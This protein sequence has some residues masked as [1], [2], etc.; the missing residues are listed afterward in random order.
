MRTLIYILLATA[1]LFAGSKPS[2]QQV[3][4]SYGYSGI[5]VRDDSLNIDT[6][7]A[8]AWKSVLNDTSNAITVDRVSSV[9]LSYNITLAQ[10]DSANVLLSMG[11]YDGGIAKWLWPGDYTRILDYTLQSIDSAFVLDT[12]VTGYGQRELFVRTCDKVK[13]VVSAPAQASNTDTV[14]I[15]TM[16]LRLKD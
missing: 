5:R 1:A 16:Y 14:T 6:T 8:S 2:Y 10:T 15:G 12:N 3:L 13:F 4:N 7:G 11:C 9:A